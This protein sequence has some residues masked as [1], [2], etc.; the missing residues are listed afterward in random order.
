MT[1]GVC[2]HPACAAA[3]ACIIAELRRVRANYSSGR[4]DEFRIKAVERGIRALEALSA[5]LRTPEVRQLT[6]GA[7]SGCPGSSR[8]SAAQPFRMMR[9]S[10]HGGVRSAASARQNRWHGCADGHVILITMTFPVSSLATQTHP[11]CRLAA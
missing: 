4:R 5:P 6:P 1:N 3:P 9:H 11:L 10:K 7:A 8:T 2:N